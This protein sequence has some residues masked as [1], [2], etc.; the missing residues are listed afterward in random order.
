M[1]YLEF[2]DQFSTEYEFMEALGNLSY[3]EAKT[4]IDEHRL[5][6]RIKTAR[7]EKWHRARKMVKLHGINVDLHADG[8]LRIV[9]Y[10]DE[11]E[12]DGNDFEYWYSLDAG[13]TALFLERV[14][15]RYGDQKIEIEEWLLE[16]IDC[17]GIG[18]DLQEKW[19]QMGLHGSHVVYEDYPGGIFRETFF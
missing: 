3:E 16:N 19:M 10:E 1:H 7:M 4:M 2:A 9:F 14:P 15:S 8:S 11:S 18:G 5:P 13:N 6:D 12:F 17:G